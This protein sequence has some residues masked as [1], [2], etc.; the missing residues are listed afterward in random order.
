V[1]RQRWILAMALAQ[2]H[3]FNQANGLISTC[4][5][6]ARHQRQRIV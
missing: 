1:E 4:A 3:Q 2:R 5:I 6:V